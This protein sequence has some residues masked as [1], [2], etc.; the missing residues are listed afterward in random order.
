MVVEQKKLALI[1]LY[2]LLLGVFFGAV[3]G[4]FKF[5]RLYFSLNYRGIKDRK[6]KNVFEIIIVF[7]E[8]V[9]YSF[10][11]AVSTCIFIYYMNAGRFR[12]IVL[13]GCAIGFIVYKN[14]IGNLVLKLSGYILQFVFLVLKKLFLYTVLPVLRLF[15]FLYDLTLGRVISELYTI[16]QRS[17]NCFAADKG[18]GI[19]RKKG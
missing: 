1:F 7:F 17:A 9:F 5:R 14:T 11:C 12:G 19:I 18:F 15:T 8:D 4:L 3:Y 6:G 2:S 13:I 16:F 10:V